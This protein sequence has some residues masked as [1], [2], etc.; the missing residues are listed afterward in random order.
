MLR[1]IIIDDVDV[2]RKEN[3]IAIEKNCP[4][5]H[6]IG[7]ATSVQTGV[8]AIKQYAPDLVF[9]DV[10][11]GDGTGFD[12][13]K[14]LQPIKFKVI[15]VSGHEGFAVKAFRCSAIDYLLKPINSKELIEAVEKTETALDKEM[16]ELKLNTLF[17]NIERPKNLQKIIL[18]T[19]EKI[20]SVNIQDVIHC[21]G[22]T[23]YTTF[24][25]LDGS[26]I[27]VSK[28]LKEYEITLSDLGFFRPHQSHLINMAY[29]DHFIKSDGGYIVLKNKT[30]VPLSLRKKVEFMAMLE[31]L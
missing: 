11:M 25:L 20:F 29:F 5:V 12:L 21:Q 16:M 18:K 17:S 14:K 2:V 22:E 3:R 1:A 8:E 19:A 10:E 9:L 28:N 13:L 4:H 24:Y 30:K 23:N 31:D 26:K 15:F 6:I 27:I 7:E